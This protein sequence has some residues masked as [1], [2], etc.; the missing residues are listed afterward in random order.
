[1]D[2]IISSL[3]FTILP[4]QDTI[5]IEVMVFNDLI[6]EETE[7][8]DILIVNRTVEGALL[9]RAREFTQVQIQDFDSEPLNCH[10][11]DYKYYK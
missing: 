1:M 11:Y 7:Y 2:Y 4:G 3:E 9:D 8:F 5:P 6:V 10:Y